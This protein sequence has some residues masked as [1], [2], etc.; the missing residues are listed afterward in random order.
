MVAWLSSR[1]VFLSLQCE[2]Y[3]QKLK[4]HDLK[5]WLEAGSSDCTA[6]N[7][8]QKHEAELEVGALTAL[9]FAT[10]HILHPP[11][12]LSTAKAREVKSS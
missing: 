5:S 9:H 1:E 8:C 6:L 4:K 10:L 3:R 7:T 11:C 12:V 2:S